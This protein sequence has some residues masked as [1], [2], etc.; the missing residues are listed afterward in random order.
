MVIIIFIII[1]III[2]VISIISISIIISSLSSSSLWNI[3]MRYTF[4]SLL[5]VS[6]N[7][8]DLYID[9]VVV[10]R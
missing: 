2:R 8:K 3:F 6:D 10:I 9:M 1:I 4:T 7:L 5:Y